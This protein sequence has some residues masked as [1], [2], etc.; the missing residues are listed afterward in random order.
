VERLGQA[1][2][3]AALDFLAVVGTAKHLEEFADLLIT[4]RP[5]LIPS[6]VVSYNEVDPEHRRAYFHSNPA[7]SMF[8]GSEQILERY[9][10][11]N[12]LV[13]YHAHTGDGSARTWS[14]FITQRQLHSTDLY[15]ELFRQL[16]IEREMVA[17]LPAARPL[18]IGIV[19]MRSGRDFNDRDRMMLDLLRPHLVNAYTSAVA[20]AAVRW[21]DTAL[22]G[23]MV[24]VLGPHRR[25]AY[26]SAPAMELL[27]YFGD[28]SPG[29]LPEP[30]DWLAASTAP[31]PGQEV[32][33]EQDGVR[34]V[35]RMLSPSALF[36]RQER[37]RIAPSRLRTLGLSQREGEVLTLVAQGDR[38]A[39]IAARLVISERTVKKHL[40]NV[41]EKLGVR[42]R[43]QAVA[44][45]LD[46]ADGSV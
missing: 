11:Q 18:L 40:E 45:A 44:V 17:T 12:P 13:V 46:A 21:T 9:M 20:R 28:A 22:P 10:D 1:D 23:D 29:I 31:L 39:A 25:I 27:R 33:A 38:N 19:L 35:A 2:L 8:D 26:A 34:V 16:D 6:D 30:L 43:T 3:R 15:N 37:R 14:D 4:G 42:S 32:T 24:V 5:R 7:E 41:Y 36:L